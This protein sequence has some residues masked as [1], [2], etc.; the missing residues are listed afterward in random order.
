MRRAEAT[1]TTTVAARRAAVGAAGAGEGTAAMRR[2]MTGMLA[3]VTAALRRGRATGERAAADAGR[4][5]HRVDGLASGGGAV[6]VAVAAAATAA[7]VGAA[8]GAGA[9]AVEAAGAVEAHHS[10]RARVLST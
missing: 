9:V 3:V 8:A 5:G 1:T 7:G 4:G 6:G 2:V 10:P